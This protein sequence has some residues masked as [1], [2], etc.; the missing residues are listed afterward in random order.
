M[1][2]LQAKNSFIHKN[3]WNKHS[4]NKRD[5]ETS[6]HSVTN[7]HSLRTDL[8][9]SIRKRTSKLDGCWWYSACPSF[10][11]SRPFR[12]AAPGQETRR[13]ETP[14][15]PVPP[16]ALDGTGRCRRERPLL[17]WQ[18]ERIKPKYSTIKQFK[19]FINIY[20][21]RASHHITNEEGLF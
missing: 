3:Y 21:K 1:R 4:F 17:G 6:T 9:T 16:H 15:L 13:R 11:W 14:N 10:P 18:Q 8:E 7:T 2:H 12:S 19:R 20:H 5:T